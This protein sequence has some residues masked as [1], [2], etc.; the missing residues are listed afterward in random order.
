[1]RFANGFK[2]SSSF[3]ALTVALVGLSL[4]LLP[5]TQAQGQDIGR[6]L[7]AAALLGI[8]GEAARAGQQQQRRPQGTARPSADRE[9]NRQ[10]QVALNQF[11]YDTGNPDGVLG[12]RSRA[13]ISQ[14]QNAMGYP[15]TGTLDAE[16]RGFLTASAQ[17]AQSDI[18]RA[19]YDEI[20][21][22]GGPRALLRVYRNEQLGIAPPVLQAG[23]APAPAPVAPAP[24]PAPAAPAPA[25]APVAAAPA[26]PAVAARP[27]LPQTEDADQRTA[28]SVAAHCGST[29]TRVRAAGRQSA[30]T[31]TDIDLA[32]SQ[33]FCDA[34][35]FAI[36]DVT[37]RIQDLGLDTRELSASCIALAVSLDPL[38][39]DLAVVETQ[40]ALDIAT[41]EVVE[42]FGDEILG[43]PEGLVE[44]SVACLGLSYRGDDARGALS[45][46]LILAALG[47]RAYAE[48]VGHHLQGGFG[49]EI[50][51]V[52]A[53]QW[54][55]LATDALRDGATPAFLPG[56][57][58]ARVALLDA[59]VARR[60]A[61][62]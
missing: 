22:R 36:S 38:L 28:A 19:P 4:G 45:A 51:Q 53:D 9:P 6:A 49:V 29:E 31:L 26:A 50:E 10:T 16:Q 2:G 13:A 12:P 54:F 61:Q 56:L 43:Q 7:A 27:E 55:T 34:R 14:F 62:Q 52:L 1:M 11:G 59:V 60:A 17:R 8:I 24:A 23:F 44:I 58:P 35:T 18:Y 33:E 25:P 40:V 39:D 46:A 48:L 42:M 57:T 47:E 20:H 3:R 5:G 15:A 21:R 37:R 32:L 41:D 30:E